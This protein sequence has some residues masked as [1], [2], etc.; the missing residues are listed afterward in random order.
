MFV[1]SP[2]Q[3]YVLFLIEICKGSRFVQ[4][5]AE[6]N[7]RATAVPVL[8]NLLMEGRNQ[9]RHK[10]PVPGTVMRVLVLMLQ[11]PSA[12]TSLSSAWSNSVM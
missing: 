11:V 10:A 7:D 2:G 9:A 1:F 8:L 3:Q 5:H 6:R 12:V 4:T